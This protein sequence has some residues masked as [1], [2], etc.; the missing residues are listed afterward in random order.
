MS[1]EAAPAPAPEVSTAFTFK[2]FRLPQFAIMRF[3]ARH[4][5][6]SAIIWG[7]IF[8]AYT[9][10]KVLNYVKLY[11][12]EAQRKQ[13]ADTLGNNVGIEALLGVAHRID[14]VPGY[15]TWNMLCILSAGAAVWALLLATKHFRGEEDAGRTELMLT[16]Q[17]TSARAATNTLLGL[18]AAWVLLFVVTG[19]GMMSV[20]RANGVG[21]SSQAGWFMALAIVCS[22]AEFIAVGAFVSQLMPVR[23]RASSL[24][25]A[26]FGVFY[27]FRILADTTSAHWLLNITPLGWVERL[28]P[29]YGSRPVWLVPI[30]AFVLTFSALAIWLAKNR[31]LGDSLLADHDT[32]RS[33]TGLLNSPFGAGLRLTGASSIGWLIAIG[34]TAT[35]YGF[36]AKSATQ[37]F[38]SGNTRHLLGTITHTSVV[39]S[40]FLGIIFMLQMVLLMCYVVAAAASV[41]NDEAQGYLDNLLVRAVSRTRWFAG[42]VA[43]IAAVATAACLLIAAATWAGVA[44]E[45]LGVTFYTLLMAALNILPPAALVLGVTLFAFGFMPRLTSLVGYG[46]IGWSFLILMLG[47]GLKLNHWVL[48]TSV[49]QHVSLAPA[50]PAN[51]HTNAMLVLAALVLA[52]LGIWRF[53]SRDLQTE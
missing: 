8:A 33:H 47:S 46:V 5:A 31:D 23:A 44:S 4:A 36:L 20:G 29:L 12:T 22:A 10:S 49:L 30:F 19:L 6:L 48:D 14:T 53:T 24:G 40:G 37:A 32:A 51:W 9:A 11:S 15:T 7:A 41:R 42:R 28:Q 3:V 50:T 21:F 39:A 1:A 45:H 13:L 38:S 27:L 26:I 25:A 16:G 43:I 35:F 34:F 18:G 17:T 2:R 52:L